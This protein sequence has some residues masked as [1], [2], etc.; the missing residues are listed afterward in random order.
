[1]SLLDLTVILELRVSLYISRY[2]MVQ[3]SGP[4]QR[5][6]APAYPTVLGGWPNNPP[7]A[8]QPE[9][10]DDSIPYVPL[11][12]AH[13]LTLANMSIRIPEPT[14]ALEKV[15]TMRRE[16]YI[17]VDYDEDDLRIFEAAPVAPAASWRAD[18][19][20]EGE[21]VVDD[22]K[23]DRAWVEQCIAHLIP[24]PTESSVAA[25]TALQRELKGILKEQK[26]AR[27]LRELGWYL[28]EE[29][30]GDNLYQWIVELH[31]F[32]PTLPIAQDMARWYVLEA[33]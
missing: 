25:T 31:S 23:H 1:M 32:D 22:W 24:P 30:I 28:P 11:D 26:A 3:G 10:I 18:G 16:E 33:A 5:A 17:S 2:L 4:G 15:L 13:P 14:F 20:E 21:E 7:Q 9:E 29:L 8:P 19:D 12:P 6:P 27:S